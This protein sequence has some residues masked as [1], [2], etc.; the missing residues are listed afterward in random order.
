M[1]TTTIKTRILT[2]LLKGLSITILC[3]IPVFFYAC[4]GGTSGKETAPEWTKRT[5]WKDG[6]NFFAV[7]VHSGHFVNEQDAYLSALRELD[8]FLDSSLSMPGPS[9]L[10]RTGV[11]TCR[12][13]KKEHTI[14]GKGPSDQSPAEPLQQGEASEEFYSEYSESEAGVYVR[15]LLSATGGDYNMELGYDCSTNNINTTL[16][17]IPLID[18][19]FVKKGETVTTFVLIKYDETLLKPETNQPAAT[20]AE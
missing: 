7:G 15:Y 1:K 3:L 12:S 17:T 6:R 16:T 11:V 20:K 10:E 9:G 2:G 13:A 14:E 8:R 19:Y 4:S 18:S 5:Y